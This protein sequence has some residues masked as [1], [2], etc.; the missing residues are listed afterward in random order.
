MS[1]NSQNSQNKHFEIKGTKR[2]LKTD[3]SYC[4]KVNPQIIISMDPCSDQF[5]HMVKDQRD[6]LCDNCIIAIIDKYGSIED[7]YC[8]ECRSQNLKQIKDKAIRVFNQAFHI[9]FTERTAKSAAMYRE[10]KYL[11]R[12]FMDEP[13]IVELEENIKNCGCGDLVN[14]QY[15]QLREGEYAL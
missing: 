3:L 2:L 11:L 13:E 9:Y 1:Q 8:N 4:G 14:C 7:C 12:E 6:E 5:K 15:C 10:A